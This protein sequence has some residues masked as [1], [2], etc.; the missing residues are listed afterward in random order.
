MAS[1][2]RW[3]SRGRVRTVMAYGAGQMRGTRLGLWSGAEIAL[4]CHPDAGRGLSCGQWRADAAR[5]RATGSPKGDGRHARWVL[6]VHQAAPQASIAKG[7]HQNGKCDLSHVSRSRPLRSPVPRGSSAASL[8]KGRR[9]GARPS[10][11]PQATARAAVAVRAVCAR[12]NTTS[13][14]L[15]PGPQSGHVR[16]YPRHPA[17][18][19]DAADRPDLRALVDEC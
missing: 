15:A 5:F 13:A 1:G 10:M 3:R 4:G 17:S 8:A 16:S 19:H 6:P 12:V 11:H 7:N 18:D 9:A 2:A 14:E